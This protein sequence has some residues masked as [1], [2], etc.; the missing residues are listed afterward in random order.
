M[1][2]GAPEKKPGRLLSIYLPASLGI[3]SGAF[4]ECGCIG[5]L[6]WPQLVLEKAGASIGFFLFWWIAVMICF[7]AY[8]FVR[9]LFHHP[10]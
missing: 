9:G 4:T 5:P 10:N 2:E 3:L 6:P 8:H 7:H 1:E